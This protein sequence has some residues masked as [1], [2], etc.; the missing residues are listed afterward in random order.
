MKDYK[1]GFKMK[2]GSK[3]VDT[4]SAFNMKDAKNIADSPMMNLTSVDP[5][6]GFNQMEDQYG[7][8]YKTAMESLENNL[9]NQNEAFME[10]AKSLQDP[11]DDDDNG[12]NMSSD[13]D[14]YQNLGA[15]LKNLFK[16]KSA[17]AKAN[18]KFRQDKREAKRKAQGGT[19]VGNFLRKTFKTGNQNP[20]L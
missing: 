11:N 8:Y 2:M 20:N 19:K 5:G 9:P 18:Q 15:G 7:D 12:N 17:T 6:G 1:S 14:V 3:Q 10:R 13:A 4:P 16:P